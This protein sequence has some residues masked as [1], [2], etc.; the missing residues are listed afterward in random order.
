[1]MHKRP[2]PRLNAVLICSTLSLSC[3]DHREAEPARVAPT[4]E[5]EDAGEATPA[6]KAPKPKANPAEPAAPEPV[7]E[8]QSPPELVAA[9]DGFFALTLRQQGKPSFED[10]Q[11]RVFETDDETVVFSHGPWILPVDGTGTLVQDRKWLAGLDFSDHEPE[12]FPM[13]NAWTVHEL[14]GRSPDALLMTVTT[15]DPY[16]S[17]PFP[18]RAYVWKGD[19]WT[20]TGNR[21]K[22]YWSY[23]DRLSPWVEGSTLSH[24]GF[25]HRYEDPDADASQPTEAQA[26]VCDKAIAS[27]RQVTVVAGTGK[28]PRQAQGLSNVRATADGHLVGLGRAGVVHYSVE[29]DLAVT[30]ALPGDPSLDGL[31]LFAADHA[32]AFGSIFDGSRSGPYIAK[33]DGRAWV[34]VPGPDCED[35]VLA[36]D[37]APD[38]NLHVLCS[39]PPISGPYPPGVLWERSSEGTWR[40]VDFGGS[41]TEWVTSFVIQSDARWVATRRGAYG[42]RKPSAVLAVEHLGDVVRHFFPDAA[43]DE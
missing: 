1:M 5:H 39:R 15:M 33:F 31:E 17:G 23:P 34:Q 24:R 40:Q 35:S 41:P 21:N 43:L 22:H 6:P 2:S 25:G 14:G 4:P 27:A 38:A 32:Y 36:L 16:G 20:A 13:L 12:V 26:R 19:R 11:F 29:E 37:W 18:H 28:A 8:A 30:R 9:G 42:S 3:S 10:D 7:E